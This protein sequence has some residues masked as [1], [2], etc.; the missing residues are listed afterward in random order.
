MV[1][2]DNQIVMEDVRANGLNQCL[3]GRLAN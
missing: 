1:K 2:R 3:P